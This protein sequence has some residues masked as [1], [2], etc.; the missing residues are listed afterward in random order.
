MRK[1]R[2]I[3]VDEGIVVLFV[4]VSKGLSPSSG[5]E[6]IQRKISNYLDDL[7]KC[8]ILHTDIRQCC[9]K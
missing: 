4:A 3:E 2:G 8:R 5:P 9:S 6:I 1:D 7:A